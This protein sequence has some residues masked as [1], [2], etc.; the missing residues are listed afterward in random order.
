MGEQGVL[1]AQNSQ[2]DVC[3]IKD[4]IGARTLD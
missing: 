3:E 4:S 1:P 2:R